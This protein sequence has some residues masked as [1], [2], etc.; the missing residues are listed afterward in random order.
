MILLDCGLVKVNL[1]FIQE[2]VEILKTKNVDLV[3][4]ASHLLKWILSET[5]K[6]LPVK[7]QEKVQSLAGL[8]VIASDF[9]NQNLRQFARDKFSEII[10]SQ[11]RNNYIEDEPLDNG[12]PK[13]NQ[14]TYSPP[15]SIRTRFA[16]HVD[17]TTFRNLVASSEVI[18]IKDFSKWNW[19]FIYDIVRGPILNSKRFDELVRNKFLARFIH[20]LRPSSR[21]FS[22]FP[23]N[24]VLI[25][26][27][28][29]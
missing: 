8:F 6:K 14:Q 28:R 7:Y 4:R 18:G 26:L 23:I 5:D 2:I 9:Q 15:D 25:V 20:Y 29:G 21:Q 17:D 16:Y 1:L 22:D 10:E 24:E 11:I 3:D 12:N 13:N 19:D 27:F